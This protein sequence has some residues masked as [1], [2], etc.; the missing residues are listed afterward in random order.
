M[1]ESNFHNTSNIKKDIVYI[2]MERTP[3]NRWISG[4]FRD[5]NDAW[6]HLDRETKRVLNNLNG[7]DDVSIRVSPSNEN[8][9]LGEINGFYI[10]Q[11]YTPETFY[12]TVAAFIEFD[13]IP[14]VVN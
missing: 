4:I 5:K 6:K 2:V 11:Y 12:N 13:I 14:M 1:T 3:E 7:F 10:L 9:R 8:E